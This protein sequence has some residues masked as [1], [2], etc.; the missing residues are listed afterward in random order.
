MPIFRVAVLAL[1]ALLLATPPAGAANDDV[2]R[3]IGA[4][5][6]DT[7]VSDDLHELTD[8]IGGRVTGSDANRQAVAW[9]ARKFQQ[10][11]IAVATEDFVM[12]RVWDENVATAAVTGDVSFEAS[13]VAKPFSASA[14][15][16]SARLVDAGFGT[17]ADI[18][19]LGDS[20]NGAWALVET[21]VLDDDLG[22]GGLFAE[23]ADAAA[24]EPRVIAA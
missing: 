24:V 21:L 9:A 13:V 6:G 3:L 1:L 22:L 14:N 15:A 11:E 18:E 10:A 4:L 23:Y 16:M 5:L 20:I 12:P 8:T 17:D 7:P 2:D 19:R